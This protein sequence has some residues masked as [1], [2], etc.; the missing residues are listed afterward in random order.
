M[1]TNSLK[2]STLP[3]AIIAVALSLLAACGTKRTSVDI[4][5]IEASLRAQVAHQR[6]SLQD[7]ITFF[8]FEPTDTGAVMVPTVRV[9][10]H[11]R[12]DRNTTTRD[13]AA[14]V[15]ESHSIQNKTH[16]RVSDLPSW[17]NETLYQLTIGILLLSI[18]VYIARKT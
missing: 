3:V 9:Q 4:N 16:T 2:F 5:E 15:R 11:A 17:A 13:T 12:A 18:V 8:R 6:L 10:R 7:T 1:H 14:A